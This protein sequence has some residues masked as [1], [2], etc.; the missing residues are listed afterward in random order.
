F[1]IPRK[2]SDEDRARAWE[3]MDKTLENKDYP[4]E[5]KKKLIESDSVPAGLI[6]EGKNYDLIMIGASKEGFFKRMFL[7]EIPEKV[8]RH[9]SSSVMIV[10][11]YDGAVKSWIKKLFG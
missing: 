9:S 3:Y 5:V 8:A 1:V 4:K 6:R 11:K 7:G 10:K 2:V